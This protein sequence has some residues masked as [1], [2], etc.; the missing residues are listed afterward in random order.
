[1]LPGQT[2]TQ[3]AG[4][5][6]QTRPSAAEKAATAVQA[7]T[8]DDYFKQWERRVRALQDGD[9]DDAVEATAAAG[10]AAGMTDWSKL[11]ASDIG[12]RFG[13]PMTREE[14]LE[15][16]K[17]KQNSGSGAPVV[18]RPSGTS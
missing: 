2:P 18:I 10:T 1:M 14:F 12:V 17:N 11:K 16:R 5:T 6:G 3:P 4:Q 13:K 15:Y 7:M 9:D 8:L